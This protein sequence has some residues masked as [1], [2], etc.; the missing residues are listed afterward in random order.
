MFPKEDAGQSIAAMCTH[1]EQPACQAAAASMVF[2][3]GRPSQS[4]YRYARTFGEGK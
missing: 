4:D 1:N 3:G 2:A